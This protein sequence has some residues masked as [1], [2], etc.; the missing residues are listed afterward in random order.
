MKPA[1]AGNQ[2]APEKMITAYKMPNRILS[3]FGP[4]AAVVAV[5][6]TLRKPVAVPRF[7][8]LKVVE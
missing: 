7:M 4:P 8:A 1:V 2:A 5:I 6:R 3:M